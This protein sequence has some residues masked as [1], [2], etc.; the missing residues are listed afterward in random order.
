M[1]VA[2]PPN[3]R[4]PVFGRHALTWPLPCA[5]VGACDGLKY[6]RRPGRDA[7]TTM[8]SA[9]V[10]VCAQAT[11]DSVGGADGV[12]VGVGGGAGVGVG[13]GVGVG[14]GGGAG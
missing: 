1:K 9:H 11:S 2:L 5:P 13:G 7:L 10:L 6:P 8:P 4:D 3:S 12:G 14:V